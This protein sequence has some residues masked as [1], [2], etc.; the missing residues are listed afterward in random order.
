MDGMGGREGEIRVAQSPGFGAKEL[1][2]L[3]LAVTT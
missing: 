3:S 1:A 2:V